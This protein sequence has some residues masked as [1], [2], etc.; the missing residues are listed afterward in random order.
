MSLN[1][2]ESIPLENIL[3]MT[4]DKGDQATPNG[5]NIDLERKHQ[6]PEK[7]S[8]VSTENGGQAANDVSTEHA[9]TNGQTRSSIVRVTE[10]NGGHST[11]DIISEHKESKHHGTQANKVIS[12]P[13]DMKIGEALGGIPVTS[14]QEINLDD[15]LKEITSHKTSVRG[16]ESDA[17]LANG[18]P[19]V[20]NDVNVNDIYKN[21]TNAISELSPVD[22]SK[23]ELKTGIMLVNGEFLPKAH[24]DA[25]KS[26][27]KTQLLGLLSGLRS[28]IRT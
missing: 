3:R 1:A 5:Q 12:E 2:F 16:N 26:G 6:K 15:H 4:N 14:F 23:I 9:Q 21:D 10:H 8:P 7:V 25:P 18:K 19:T 28:R 24:P 17:M 22:P 27:D 11:N 13:K 20:F